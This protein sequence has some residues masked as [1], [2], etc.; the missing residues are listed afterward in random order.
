MANTSKVQE[1]FS[2]EGTIALI[3]G[4]YQGLGLVLARGLGQAG[5]R[6]VLNGR[7][8]EKL[9]KA[10]LQLSQE[11]LTVHG[12]AFDVTNSEQIQAI[13][14]QIEQEVGPIDI[15]VNNAGIQR[16]G[17]LEQIE[18]ATWRELIDTNMTGTFL[19]TKHVVQGMI[20]RKAGKIINIGSLQCEIS[21]NTIAPYAA[22]K[23]GLKMLTKGMAT[24]WG[25]YNI[26]ANAIGPGYFLSEMTQPLADDPQFDSWLKARTP[27]G[28]WGDQTELV[29][30]VIFLASEASSFINGHTLYVDGGVL[31]TI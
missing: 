17:P 19:V 1:L 28:R 20:A 2:L 7:S 21:R 26:Q 25:K 14:P 13:V 22:S 10:I 3:T 5:A 31:A 18:E 15:L 11:G 23:G 6:I 29:G 4:S 16:R 24:D 30:A 27:M 8:Q 9:E 12:Y